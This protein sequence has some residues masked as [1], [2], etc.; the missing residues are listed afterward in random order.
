MDARGYVTCYK[1]LGTY[2][3]AWLCP[4]VRITTW[5]VMGVKY[6]RVKKGQTKGVGNCSNTLVLT[7]L[8]SMGKPNVRV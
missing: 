6:N 2:Y 8:T 3:L 1:T 5:D 4:L 7:T